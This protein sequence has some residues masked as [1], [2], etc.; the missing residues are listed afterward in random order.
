MIFLTHKVKVVSVVLLVS[1]LTACTSIKPDLP[2]VTH[3]GLQLVENTEFDAVY[4]DPNAR[5]DEYQKYGLLPCQ[6]AFK[7]NWERDQN[8]NRMDLSNRVTQA[9][10]DRIKQALSEQCDKYFKEA[11]L[12]D[13]AYDLVE[14]FN[15]GE[16]VL[17][18]RPNIIN[19]DVSAP[20]LRTASRTRSYTTSSGEMT[21]Y[22]ELIDSTTS[23]ILARVIDE[24][25]ARDNISIQITNS[26][27]NMADANIILREWANKLR[28]GME[29]VKNQ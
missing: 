12:E 1:C 4:I 26:V 27:T 2:A 21:L 17:I 6:V 19:L 28:K 13:P 22:L 24:E 25:A 14:E 15:E 23:D 8:R 16:S 11:L 18:L 20:D 10:V 29:E 9:D 5:F 7:K 3:D